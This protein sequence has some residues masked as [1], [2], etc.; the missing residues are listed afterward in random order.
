MY[1]RS[2]PGLTR[3]VFLLCLIAVLVGSPVRVEAQSQGAQR[4]QRGTDLLQEWQ[5]DQHLYV[6]GE[7]GVDARGLA[8]LETWLDANGPNWTVLLMGDANGETYRD[9]DGYNHSGAAAVEYAIGRGLP[10]IGGFTALID[11][12]TGQGNGAALVILLR[13]RKFFYSGSETHNRRGLGQQSWNGDLDRP[14]FRAMSNG[15]RVV[16]A[17]KGTVNEL[18]AR[19]TRRLQSEQKE[20]ERQMRLTQQRL[21]E[22]GRVVGR[23]SGEIDLLEQELEAFKSAHPDAVGDLANPE[24]PLLRDAEQAARAA[25]GAGASGEALKLAEPVSEFVAT[26][27]RSLSNYESAPAEFAQLNQEISG[28]IPGREGWGADRL[29]L[30]REELAKAQDAYRAGQSAYLGHLENSREALRSARAEFERAAEAL[31]AERVRDEAAQAQAEAARRRAWATAKVVA[32]LVAAALG[33]LAYFLNR[34]RRAAKAEAESLVAS[35]EG[36]F[37]DKTDQ[38][39][40]LLDRT[41]VVVG[42]EIEL[43]KR[44]YTGETL[45]LGKQ[46]IEDVDQL[47]IM[48]STV[49]R[50]LGDARE[51]VYPKYGFQRMF[52]WFGTSRY[53]SALSK[54]RDEMITF[55]PQDGVQLLSRE[56]IRSGRPETLLGKLESYQPFALSFP[57]LMEEFNRRAARA[58]ESLDLIEASWASITNELDVVRLKI[59]AAGEFESEVAA[60]ASGDELFLLAD[61]FGELVPSGQA[62]LDEAVA[63]GATD[64]V[65]ALAGPLPSARRKAAD[66]TALSELV[67]ESRQ[68]QF[69]A[70]RDEI[71]RLESSGHGTAWVGRF[72]GEYSEWADEIARRGSGSAVAD[73]IAELGEAI[74]DLERSCVRARQLATRLAET[75]G[76][77]IETVRTAV[78][79]GRAEIGAALGVPGDSVMREQGLDPDELLREADELRVAASLAIDRG[80]VE[81]A[82]AAL[83]ETAALMEEGLE[84]V[85]M[86]RASFESH[87]DDSEKSE[88]ETESLTAELG[89]H[90]AVLESLMAGY[91]PSALEL[92]AGDPA[93]PLHGESITDHTI[94]AERGLDGAREVLAD[95]RTSYKAARLIEASSLLAYAGDLQFHVASLYREIREQEE[96]I[97]KMERAN[98]QLL[99]KLE[100]EVR[101]MGGGIE[102]PR[103]MAPTVTAFEAAG[104]DLD[105]ARLRVSSKPGDPFKA[106]ALLDGTR[107]QLEIVANMAQ[108][109]R[110][111]F[112]EL[113]RSLQESA[114]HLAKAK[115]TSQRAADDRIPDSARIVELQESIGKLFI[116]QVRCERA[117]QQPHGDWA[118]LDREA[119][120]IAA[121]AARASAEIRGELAKAE[122]AVAAIS[123]ASDSVREAGGWIGSLGVRIPGTPGAGRLHEAR[124]ALMSGRYLKAHRYADDA[125]RAARQAIV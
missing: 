101:A 77:E 21:A 53:R 125:G 72:L 121:A 23:L 80:G 119:D 95:A 97:Q 82:E 64:P 112:D 33:G 123:S 7:V 24:V 76:K 61:V 124:S 74:A 49:A 122:A 120:T 108:S 85:A 34:R 31:R 10:G 42:S 63:Q 52:N 111:L 71:E 27:R 9:G 79:A 56:E 114:S 22:A 84:L 40:A 26:H 35:W 65:G 100:D 92:S 73:E 70:M 5:A 107:H 58:T 28:V 4:L 17:V 110:E 1:T 12:R 98:V 45:R 96:K 90:R 67:L 11:E 75:A 30:A 118:A 66:A 39:F 19:L 46:T 93:S 47:F 37:G 51:E 83:D 60:A 89:R 8:D 104:R 106:A 50:Q 62:D 117:L 54:L 99:K 81:A 20:R 91:E 38:L 55:S 87:M 109:D 113:S 15:R 115:N 43:P 44:G 13:E 41:T 3:Q 94:K 116:D 14:A 86:T 102:D 57:K 88:R 105:S 32:G 48:S 69:P 59:N 68:A 36:G 2:A 78:E 18:G 103:T 16:D 29:E 6:K 25:L